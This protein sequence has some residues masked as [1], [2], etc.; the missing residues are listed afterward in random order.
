M[1]RSDW[2]LGILMIAM[3]GLSISGIGTQPHPSP[4]GWAIAGALVVGGAVLFLRKPFSLYV[5]MASALVTLLGGVLALAHH[6]ELSL[7][8]PAAMS[9]VVGLYLFVRLAM[10]K[11]YFGQRRSE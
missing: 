10:A 3:G 7:P 4:A 6:P 8:V 5:A 1:M 9:I 2:S 11:A